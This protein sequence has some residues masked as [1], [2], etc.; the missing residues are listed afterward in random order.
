M[1]I[2]KKKQYVLTSMGNKIGREWCKSNDV[3]KIDTAM[4]KKWGDKLRQTAKNE[5]HLLAE[6]LES[7]DGEI[8]TILD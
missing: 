5:P 3:R 2:S 7:I 1:V 8:D 4:L 6:V